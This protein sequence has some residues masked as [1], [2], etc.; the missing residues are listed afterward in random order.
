MKRYPLIGCCGIDCCLC[1]RY[2]TDG[3]SAC[4][5]CGA[6]DFKEKHPSCGYLTCCVTKHGFETCAECPDYPCARFDKERGGRDS[7]VTHRKVFAN[8]DA[9]RG[10]GLSP[11]LKTQK[12][13]SDVLITLLKDF[14]DGRS[15]SYFCLAAALLP[16][17]DL[18]ALADTLPAIPPHYE[19]KEKNKLVRS[20]IDLLAGQRGIELVLKK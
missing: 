5:G 4:P 3:P 12:I 20:L 6:P 19:A 10:K 9:I 15:K 16:I 7:F 1:P 11:F 17:G 8:L 18:E 2:H 13:R 14:D